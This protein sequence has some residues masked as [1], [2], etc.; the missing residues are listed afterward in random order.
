MAGIGQVLVHRAPFNQLYGYD[1]PT[2]APNP[3]DVQQQAV[4]DTFFF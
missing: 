3:T 2:A 4:A 1:P